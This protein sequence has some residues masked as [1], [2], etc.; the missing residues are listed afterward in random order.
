MWPERSWC[1]FKYLTTTKPLFYL[2]GSG[3]AK[4]PKLTLFVVLSLR[5]DL[6]PL[7]PLAPQHIPAKCLTTV[8]CQEWQPPPGS[9]LQSCQLWEMMG[10]RNFG[11]LLDDIFPSLREISWNFGNQM[12]ERWCQKGQVQQSMRQ[13]AWTHCKNMTIDMV[14]RSPCESKFILLSTLKRRTQNHMSD[15]QSNEWFWI[16]YTV[17]RGGGLLNASCRPHACDQMT[18]VILQSGLLPQTQTGHAS[19]INVPSDFQSVFFMIGWSGQ[20]FPLSACN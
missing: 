6:A 19:Y 11:E 5:S 15:H 2:P 14:A 12:P 10:A 9:R 7:A 20:C 1:I 17:E 16:T 18:N 4:L 3:T 8:L 13:F